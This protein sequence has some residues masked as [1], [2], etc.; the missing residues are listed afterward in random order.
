MSLRLRLLNL[1]LRRI[2][3]PALEK[4]APLVARARFERQA[5]LFRDPPLALYLPADLGGVP[6]LWASVRARRGGV[7]LYLHGGAHLMGS[8]ATHRAM[9][10]RLSGMTGLRAVL[11]DARLAPEH[12]FPAELD[13]AETAF[14]ALLAKGYPA[15][16][17]AIGGDS[18]GGGLAL[19]LLAR[20]LG[21]GIR[22]ACLFA[23]SPWTDLT[24][25]GVSM[26]ENAR[27]DPLLPVS[28]L[29]EAR[30]LYLAG[31]SPTDPGASPLFAD[32]PGCPPVFLQ[33]S[34][35]EILRD[36]SL[37]MADRLKG[38][39]SEAEVDLWP[40]CP[41]VWALF[42]GL[43]PEADEALSRLARFLRR[44]MPA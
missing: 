25:S 16:C 15:A 26:R 4:V 44:H 20:L 29:D 40:D 39:G 18:A 22:P 24:G 5:R 7:I 43:L 10:A 27:A 34:Q 36:D 9:L 12:P 31:A 19:A 28:R 1:W 14:M 33:V 30:G 42:Q 32:F 11:P 17:I 21:R 8:P 41:H 2:E 37:R 35:T 13:D 3:K 38:F 23:L 6:A